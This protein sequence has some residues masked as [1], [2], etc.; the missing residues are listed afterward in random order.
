M[1]AANRFSKG[2]SV[3]VAE[4]ECYPGIATDVVETGPRPNSAFVARTASSY[5]CPGESFTSSNDRAL[6]D[7]LKVSGDE[8]RVVAV[9]MYP[10]K[11]DPPSLSGGCQPSVRPDEGFETVTSVGALG[12]LGS[13]RKRLAATMRAGTP[14]TV[15]ETATISRAGPGGETTAITSGSF[16]EYVELCTN[17]DDGFLPNMMAPADATFFPNTVTTVPPSAPPCAGAKPDSVRPDGG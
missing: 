15:T 4:S 14:R 7:N 8:P 17:S 13:Y 16:V 2:S 1:Y 9:R 3:D 10:V 5:V 12:A 11:D 6:G